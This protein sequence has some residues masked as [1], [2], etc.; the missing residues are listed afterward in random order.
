LKCLRLK[1]SQSKVL[2]PI[3]YVLLGDH[4]P[5]RGLQSSTASE[6]RLLAE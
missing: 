2:G 6:F 1:L 4:K 5:E 3:D